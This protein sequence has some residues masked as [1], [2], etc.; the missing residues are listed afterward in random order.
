MQFA[1]AHP[2]PL[3]KDMDMNKFTTHTCFACP[4][5]ILCT[6]ATGLARFVL[7]HAALFADHPDIAP[8]R[9]R[10][11]EARLQDTDDF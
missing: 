7:L 3:T 4:E 6:I 9:P 8:S 11:G 2:T 5:L 1:L 10:H